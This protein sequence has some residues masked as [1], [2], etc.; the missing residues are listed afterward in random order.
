MDITNRSLIENETYGAKIQ[1]SGKR[2]IYYYSSHKV[3]K[4][5]RMS[6]TSYLYEYK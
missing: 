6:T 2:T 3:E 5:V 1:G 4:L